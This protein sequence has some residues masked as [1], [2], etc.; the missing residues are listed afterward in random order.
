MRGK[1]ISEIDVA[2][3]ASVVWDVYSTRKLSEVVKTIPNFRGKQ[4]VIGDGG[5]GTIISGEL[6][7]GGPYGAY[8]EKWVTID[9]ENRVKETDTIEGGVLD[10]G[11]V[12]Y[13]LRFEIAEEGPN[14]SRIKTIIMYEIKDE[15][16]AGNE[17]I[18]DQNLAQMETMAR[19]VVKYL[20]DTNAAAAAAAAAPL[21]L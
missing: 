4:E 13:R 15:F 9:H 12:F 21:P 16:A 19:A 20:D 10:V 7:P 5:V 17:Y 1:K 14:A 3:P 8:R 2:F 11:F 18:A 6:P